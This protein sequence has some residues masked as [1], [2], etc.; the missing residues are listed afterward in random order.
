MAGDN[1]QLVA[2]GERPGRIKAR[3]GSALPFPI[4]LLHRSLSLPFLPPALPPQAGTV[5]FLKDRRGEWG[6]Y[7]VRR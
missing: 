3:E 2:G 1:A 6:R 4:V 7:L 5:T